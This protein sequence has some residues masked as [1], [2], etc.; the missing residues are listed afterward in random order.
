MV[1][2]ARLAAGGRPHRMGPNHSWPSSQSGEVVVG[3]SE[4]PKKSHQIKE[5]GVGEEVHNLQEG[6]RRLNPDEAF[7]G[8]CLLSWPVF[9]LLASFSS[10]GQVF[11]LSAN[12]S[13]LG[14]F[15][16]SRPVFPRRLEA[17]LG[18]F[19][20]CDSAETRTLRDSLQH[21]R[22]SAQEQPFTAQIKDTE[23]FI[24]RSRNAS[25]R[26]NCWRA[27]PVW[28]GCARWFRQFH[29]QQSWMPKLPR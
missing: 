4:S 6:V 9:P 12:F 16:L 10:P 7:L 15:A 18:V 2:P 17:A 26:S 14:Q 5:D 21:A 3:F 27:P 23:D 8:Q 19:A 1:R 29:L 22:R 25:R 24:A 13:S 11:P 28:Q 20:E